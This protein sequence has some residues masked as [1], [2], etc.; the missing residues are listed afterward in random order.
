MTRSIYLMTRVTFYLVSYMKMRHQRG[1]VCFG[2]WFVLP[3][4]IYKPWTQ[5]FLQFEGKSYIYS[6][7]ELFHF[8]QLN[9]HYWIISPYFLFPVGW[10]TFA[11]FPK[12]QWFF[13]QTERSELCKNIVARLSLQWIN[14]IGYLFF[15]L[16]NIFF[17]D[18]H[19]KTQ[20]EFSDLLVKY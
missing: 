7:S 8:W 5:S 2:F 20:S 18:R 14:S 15:I 12:S 19:C 13:T 10:S 11:H 9:V 1:S 4:E 16:Q 17:I 6:Y 3:Q